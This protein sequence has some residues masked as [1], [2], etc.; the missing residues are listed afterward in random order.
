[1]KLVLIILRQVKDVRIATITNKLIL[2]LQ[3]VSKILILLMSHLSIGSLQQ[4]LAY[5]KKVTQG[6]DNG[7]QRTIC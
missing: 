2:K 1:M 6:Y 4:E 7:L 5:F 3:F